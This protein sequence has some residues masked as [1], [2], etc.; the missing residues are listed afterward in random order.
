MDGFVFER[1]VVEELVRIMDANRIPHSEVAKKAF[2]DSESS[3]KKWYYI[4]KGRRGGK[5]QSLTMADLVDLCN[6]LGERLETI[7][8]RATE[9]AAEREK[10]QEDIINRRSA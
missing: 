5:V 2:G 7:I 4:H 10:Q 3:V 8:F 6:A 1:A 9:R